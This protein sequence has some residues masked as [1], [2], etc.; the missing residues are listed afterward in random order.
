[1]GRKNSFADRMR[2]EREVLFNEGIKVGRQQI[3]D[4]MSIVLNDPEVVGKDTFGRKRLIK[5]IKAIGEGI[6]TFQR[7]WEWDPETDY[8]RAKLDE[9]LSRIYG[10]DLHDTFMKRY[11]ICREVQYKNGKTSK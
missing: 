9:Q 5:V 1:M 3:L 2:L 10:E 8:F 7:A 6:D 4:I 11:E